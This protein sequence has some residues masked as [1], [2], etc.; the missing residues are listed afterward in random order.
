MCF[1]KFQQMREWYLNLMKVFGS[2]PTSDWIVWLNYWM[3][4]DF[5][6]TS[7]ARKTY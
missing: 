3:A 5:Q 7:K 6:K 1:K 4:L 2:I